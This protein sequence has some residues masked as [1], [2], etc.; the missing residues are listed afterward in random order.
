MRLICLSLSLPLHFSVYVAFLLALR[1]NRSSRY[2]TEKEGGKDIVP[3]RFSPPPRSTAYRVPRITR[4]AGRGRNESLF[5]RGKVE[6]HRASPVFASIIDLGKRNEMAACFMLARHVGVHVAA[7]CSFPRFT[8][9]RRRWVIR[10]PNRSISPSYL[11][12]KALRRGDIALAIKRSD[13]KK[14]KAARKV[15]WEKFYFL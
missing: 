1:R 13:P 5:G 11:S 12:L 10:C 3:Y 6:S 4:S 2:V 7:F 14:D 8:H 9:Y 15:K